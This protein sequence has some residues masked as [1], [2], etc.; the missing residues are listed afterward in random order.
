LHSASA[1]DAP[2]RLASQNAACASP[3]CVT[4]RVLPSISQAGP[5]F[6]SRSVACPASA[7]ASSRLWAIRLACA[8]I[9]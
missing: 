9:V 1:A 3:W 8:R 7:S 5:F 6:G 2:R 4:V